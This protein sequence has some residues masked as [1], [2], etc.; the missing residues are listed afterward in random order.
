MEGSPLFFFTLGSLVTGG[1]CVLIW[2][3]A[4]DVFK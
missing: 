3:Y 1:V 2:Q 4:N